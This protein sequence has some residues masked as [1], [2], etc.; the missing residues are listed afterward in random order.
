MAKKLSIL[1]SVGENKEIPCHLNLTLGKLLGKGNFGSVRLASDSHGQQF[2]LKIRAWSSNKSPWGIPGDIIREAN[3]YKQF[4]HP[5]LLHCFEIYMEKCD[6]SSPSISENDAMTFEIHFKLEYA[7]QTLLKLLTQDKKDLNARFDYGCDVLAGMLF[8]HSNSIIFGDL[9]P[10]N[11]LI[12]S[13]SVAKL[14]DFGSARFLAPSIVPD[15]IPQSLLYIMPLLLFSKQSPL[16]LASDVY[17]FGLVLTQLFVTGSMHP[18]DPTGLWI[19]TQLEPLITLRVPKSQR[20]AWTK[21]FQEIFHEGLEEPT[22]TI[23]VL[24]VFILGHCPFSVHEDFYEQVLQYLPEKGIGMPTYINLLTK[25][26][27]KEHVSPISL[28]ESTDKKALVKILA[29]TVT[30]SPEVSLHQISKNPFFKTRMQK[31]IHQVGNQYCRK[32]QL[33]TFEW[34]KNFAQ[35]HAT[36]GRANSIFACALNLFDRLAIMRDIQNAEEEVLFDTCLLIATK[37]LASDRQ[38]MHIP[39]F[40][41]GVP[42]RIVQLEFFVCQYV[43]FNIFDLPLYLK[44][45]QIKDHLEFVQCI[46]DERKHHAKVEHLKIKVDEKKNKKLSCQLPTPTLISPKFNIDNVDDFFKSSPVSPSSPS[47]PSSPTSPTSPSSFS[48]PVMSKLALLRAAAGLQHQSS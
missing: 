33:E 20:E 44:C 41:L 36:W 6:P 37:W 9:K 31:R 2:A 13:E 30:W 8:L 28:L 4:P 24:L 23:F 17:S 35:W 46:L 40:E 7:P 47:F 45:G 1:T 18:F 42:P 43:A 3:I 22:Y 11:V 10:D 38:A 39:R 34:S 32:P 48:R 26:V 29:Q 19:I 16:T 14:A 25:L 12:T 5:N 27:E 15:R 21:L